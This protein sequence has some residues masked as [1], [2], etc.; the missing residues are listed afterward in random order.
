MSYDLQLFLPA[1]REI[2]EDE[3]CE[4]LDGESSDPALIL[5][6]DDAQVEA[7]HRVWAEHWDGREQDGM[8]FATFDIEPCF[9]NAGVTYN[10]VAGPARDVAERF[11]RSCVA[12][13][14]AGGLIAFDPQIDRWLSPPDSRD[15][16]HVVLKYQEGRGMVGPKSSAHAPEP[17]EQGTRSFWQRLFGRG[18]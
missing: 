3:R 14:A 5:R 11:Y 7:M 13:T 2:G 10:S 8:P 18:T 6:L 17:R 1:V 16:E 12:I 15:M 9:V 4:L